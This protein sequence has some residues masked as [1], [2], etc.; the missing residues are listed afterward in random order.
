MQD[1]SLTG[2]DQRRIAIF[3]P[4]DGQL[5][6]NCPGCAITRWP[7]E[8]PPAARRVFR[9]SVFI[10]TI[11][12]NFNQT[13]LKLSIQNNQFYICCSRIFVWKEFNLL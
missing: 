4:D 10:Q 13:I 8:H 5:I 7:G 2:H 11:F 3:T 6:M 1:F 9:Y 12:S